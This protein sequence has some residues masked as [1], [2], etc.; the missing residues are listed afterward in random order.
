MPSMLITTAG[1][2][3]RISAPTEGAKST[4]HISPRLGAG[5]FAIQVILAKGF[6]RRQFGIGP[7]FF[8]RESSSGFQDGIPL[9]WRQLAQLGRGPSFLCAG[10]F[11]IHSS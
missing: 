10:I 4:N 3:L 6:K 11:S 8:L 9:L 1:R 7:V 5:A 2:T